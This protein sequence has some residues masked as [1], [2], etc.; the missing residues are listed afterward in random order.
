MHAIFYTI[1]YTVSRAPLENWK[2]LSTEF[3][4]IKQRYLKTDRKLL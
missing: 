2:S 4:K 3:K 1:D